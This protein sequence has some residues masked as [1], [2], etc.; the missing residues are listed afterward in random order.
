MQNFHKILAVF[1]LFVS[2]VY[3]DPNVIWNYNYGSAA[4]DRA[5]CVRPAEDGGWIAAGI[6][7]EGPSNTNGDIMIYKLDQSGNSEWNREYGWPENDCAYSITELSHGGF[8]L[9]GVADQGMY[10]LDGDILVMKVDEQGDTVWTRKFDYGELDEGYEVLADADENIYIGGGIDGDIT[11]FSGEAFLM[12]LTPDGDQVWMQT[13]EYAT[14]TCAYAM[15]FAH[16]GGFILAGSEREDNYGGYGE[17][18]LIKTDEDGVQQWSRNLG[19][20]R[21]R[22]IKRTS[23]G[24]YIISGSSIKYWTTDRSHCLIKTDSEGNIEWDTSVSSV[25]YGEGMEV[26]ETDDGGFLSVGYFLT[27]KT[28]A[29]G[30]LF[31]VIPNWDN[32]YFYSLCPAEGGHFTAAGLQYPPGGGYGG[33]MVTQFDDVLGSVIVDIEPET[34]PLVVPQ[35]GSFTFDAE[36]T[37]TC[38]EIQ[39][40]IL[41]IFGN[42]C[43]WA[44]YHLFFEK[45]DIELAP[46]ETIS[47]DDIQQFIPQQANPGIYSYE[48]HL[49]ENASE[50]LLYSEYFLFEIISADGDNTGNDEWKVEGWDQA[51]AAQTAVTGFELYPAFPNPFNS[52]TVIA[53]TL[54]EASQVNLNV[55]DLQGRIAGELANGLFTA[56]THERTFNAAELSSGVY[57]VRLSAGVYNHTEKL[58]LIK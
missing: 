41:R 26:V 29:D 16:D 18:L 27:V 46:G 44:A 15:D 5:E 20:G 36:L 39:T 25:Y 4:T 48:A 24:G 33:S 37:N 28:D 19:A 49:Y 53:F 55:F 42:R 34:L 14:Q 2:A 57:F 45:S 58:I 11:G 7:C 50:D 35:G 32:S 9:S 1:L 21:A 17:I 10:G 43:G 3:A 47:K 40:V 22:N 23:D 31:G 6:F 12:K 51:P 8:V 52:E 56:G 30:N 54:P 13:Y 38:E